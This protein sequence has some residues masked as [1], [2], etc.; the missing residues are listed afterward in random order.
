MPRQY[1]K[2]TQSMLRNWLDNDIIHLAGSGG[3]RSGIRN[4]DKTISGT[5]AGV[6]GHGSLYIN[7]DN[8]VVYVNEGTRV[9]PYWTPTDFRQRAL[10]GI[11]VDWRNGIG[12]PL[13]DTNA[14]V[15]LSESGLRTFG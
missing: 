6:S 12:N 5:G 11:Y 10:I 2:N 7:S 1:M 13:A 8:G 3:P 4:A 15:T 14:S 9:S